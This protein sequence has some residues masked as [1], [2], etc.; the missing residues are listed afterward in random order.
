MLPMKPKAMMI[1]NAKKI[2]M[3]RHR[4]PSVM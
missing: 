2:A 3:G 1:E 4:R